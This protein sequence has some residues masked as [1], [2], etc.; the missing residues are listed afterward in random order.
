[1]SQHTMIHTNRAI[2]SFIEDTLTEAEKKDRVFLQSY[3]AGT[4]LLTQGQRN[5]YVLVQKTGLSK[6]YITE[7][8][9]KDFII[10]FLGEGELL[11]ELEL[12]QQSSNLTTVTALTPVTAWCITTDYFTYLISH[13]MVLNRLLM[14]SL[15]NRLAQTSARASY[16]QVYPAEYTMLKLLSVLAR[17]Q[18]A[19]SKKDLADYLGVSVRSFN[20]TLKQ[21]REKSIIHP[22]S[23]DLYLDRASFERLIQTYGEQ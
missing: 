18:T 15:A 20:R 9:G 21:L 10:Q 14:E 22:D 5:K 17:Q 23:F 8:N 12:I 7:D 1:M 4:R 19:F 6:C 3:P 16:Q 2:L 13:N 11:G